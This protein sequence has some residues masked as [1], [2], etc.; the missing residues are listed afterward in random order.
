MTDILLHHYIEQSSPFSERVRLDLGIKG[1][2]WGSVVTGWS[3]PK[4]L[5]HRYSYENGGSEM[6]ATRHDY[7]KAS[8]LVNMAPDARS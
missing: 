6:A 2:A 3:S 5:V 4:E 8:L 7:R 1:L